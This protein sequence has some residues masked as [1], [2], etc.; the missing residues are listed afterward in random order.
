MNLF[1][2]FSISRNLKALF[3]RPNDNYAVIDG[4]R[5]LSMLLV[6]VFHSFTIYVGTDQRLTPNQFIDSTPFYYDWI[7][8]A[9][10][11]VDIF[12]VISG[13]LIASL[14]L[15]DL[16]ANQKI[17]Y[18]RFY[19]RRFLRLMPAYWLLMLIYFGYKAPN[20]ENLW[21]N[22]FYVNNFLPLKEQAANWTWSLAIEEQFY[23]IFPLILALIARSKA[24]LRNLWYLFVASFIV[25]GLVIYTDE[26]LLSTP[27]YQ[28]AGDKDFH[29]HYFSVLYDNL[30]TRFGS[31]LAGVI[32]SYYHFYHKADVDRFF[33]SSWAHLVF[34]MAVV[35][36]VV[37][38]MIPIMRSNF[39]FSET[40]NLIYQMT[41]RNLF[42]AA[43]AVLFMGVIHGYR[44]SRW[45]GV[46]FESRV[47]YPLA[48][49]SYSMYLMHVIFISMATTNVYSAV[50]RNPEQ[51]F[52]MA[53]A[54]WR[55][56]AIGSVFT[57]LFAM[58][59]YLLLER[60]FIN[61]RK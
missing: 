40:F 8:G 24:P 27:M 14:L 7:W 48:Q 23:L 37:L 36:V 57:I 28:L 2:A 61:M 18:G 25:R 29:N 4:F 55:V 39:Y 12:F 5:A 19:T 11:G 16:D 47:W 41:F 45:L 59:V 30:Y 22:F 42:S 20:Y 13:F 10:K 44:G 21:A 58:V 33:Q 52:G 46:I 9:D 3:V 1:S 43:I 54:G 38:G 53:E 31:L 17:R 49:L 35:I 32:A 50:Q 15:K 6:L 34:W 56:F 26:L 51:A 60:P